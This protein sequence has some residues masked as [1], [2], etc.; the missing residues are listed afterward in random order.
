[1]KLLQRLKSKIHLAR[2][3]AVQLDYAGSIAV[4]EDLMEAVG[5]EPGELVHV[6]VVDNG[7]RFETYVI[8]APA[9]SGEIA[10]YGAAAHK[11]QRGHRLIIAAFA[12]TD[13][14]IE[15]QMILVNERN[16]IVTHLPF[17]AQAEPAELS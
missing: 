4:D 5:L 17:Q 2:V 6:W 1:M 7:E 14:W 3:T 10:V 16:Q 9:G 11:V 8:P 12:W 15:P 13:E